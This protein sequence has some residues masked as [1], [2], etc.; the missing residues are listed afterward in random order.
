M[1]KTTTNSN[2]HT[3]LNNWKIN[4]TRVK[5]TQWYCASSLPEQTAVT[6]Q[7]TTIIQGWLGG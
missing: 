3:V 5:T 6:P 1:Y 2:A 7:V 4:K